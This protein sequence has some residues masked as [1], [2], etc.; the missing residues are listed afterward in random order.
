MST[1]GKMIAVDEPATEDETTDAVA[2]QVA[3]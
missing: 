1:L 3:A 2:G